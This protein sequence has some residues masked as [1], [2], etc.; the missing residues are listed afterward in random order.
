M[1]IILPVKG[2]LIILLLLTMVL[3]SGTAMAGRQ[4]DVSTQDSLQRL[5]GAS[6]VTNGWC[7]EVG[8]IL[9]LR[10]AG[11][12]TGE[13]ILVS[14]IR[15]ANDAIPFFAGSVNSAGAFEISK[16]MTAKAPRRGVSPK[17]RFP[18]A[19]LFTIEALGVSGRL[20]AAPVSFTSETCS[21]GD[22]A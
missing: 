14:L 13:I 16:E 8:S 7:Y 3:G 5:D 11:W 1:R 20:A 22:G 15:D 6:I 2:T 4:A 17:A 10:G 21:A 18:G 19:G 9:T 12:G